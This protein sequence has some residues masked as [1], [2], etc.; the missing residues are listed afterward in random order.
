MTLTH[1]DYA[2][3]CERNGNLK[4]NYVYVAR[5]RDR[6]KEENEE[7]RK[8]EPVKH[9]H[10]I[11]NNIEYYKMMSETDCPY[12][13]V[14]YFENGESLACSLC[15]SKTEIREDDTKHWGWCPFCGAKMDGGINENHT[16][17]A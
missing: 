17:N 16:D 15:G 1:E 12:N 3:Q 5:E 10:W 14:P 11:D 7:L 4:E 6:L 2:L 13:E 9:G 8:I